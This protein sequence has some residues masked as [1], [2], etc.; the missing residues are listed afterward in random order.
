MP[1]SFLKPALLAAALG[2]VLWSSAAAESVGPLPPAATATVLTETVALPQADA[3]TAGNATATNASTT[4]ASLQPKVPSP[5]SRPLGTPRQPRARADSGAAASSDSAAPQQAPS[6]GARGDTL[7]SG[8]AGPLIAVLGLIAILAGAAA[9]VA[10][11]RGMN[12]S[13]TGG[14]RAPA[15]ILEIL[16]RYPLSRT[17]TLILLKVD[18]RVLLLSQTRTGR[19][20]ATQ[21][22]TLCELGDPE[23]VASILTKVSEADRDS[24]SG[25]FSAVLRSL[26]REA[27]D[28]VDRVPIT[29]ARRAAPTLPPPPVAAAT[30]VT[31]TRPGE[32]TGAQAA[33]SIRSR[34]H[35]IRLG[36]AA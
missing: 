15:G 30:R 17:Q 3:E 2:A 24:L 9:L 13:W 31:D 19:L 36:G 21:L 22:S 34:L 29:L 10:R 1:G 16:G 18:R 33:A 11:A 12:A 28:K 7:W 4:R 6:N 35:A 32:M 14:R 5:E 26:D 20:G 25:R 23:D 8:I 27:A